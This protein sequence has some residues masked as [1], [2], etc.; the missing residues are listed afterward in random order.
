LKLSKDKK[1]CS[2]CPSK[3]KH[4]QGV[5]DEDKYN[6]DVVKLLPPR[7]LNQGDYSEWVTV[8]QKKKFAFESN[9]DDDSSVVWQES[10]IK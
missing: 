10:Y 9:I 8:P 7:Y 3:L 2:A 6:L 5:V 4:K 1:I